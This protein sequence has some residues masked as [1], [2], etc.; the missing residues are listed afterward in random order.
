LF[1]LIPFIETAITRDI[2]IITTD[3]PR[4]EVITKDNISVGVDA[5]VFLKIVDSVKSVVNIQDVLYAVKQYSQTTLRNVIGQRDLDQLLENRKEIAVLIKQNVDVEAEKWGIDI[6]SIEL[7]N[8]ELPENLKRVMARQAEAER[9][10][11]AVIIKSKGE[12]E[13]A[14][15]LRQAADI[16]MQS[17][18]QIA[19]K[20]REYET[21]SDISYDQSNTI[22]FYPTELGS[23][24]GFETLLA[25]TSLSSP[26]TYVKKEPTSEK[27]S[28]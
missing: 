7:Q 3:I 22:V 28:S 21:L 17:K 16:L 12:V 15:S 14:R 13:A 2:R 4:Q 25:G 6:T 23:E 20:L 5:V 27:K 8:I 10:K 18:G 19:V 11:R 9:E 1:F 26:N 24:R